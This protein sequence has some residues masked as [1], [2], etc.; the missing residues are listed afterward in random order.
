MAVA[1]AELHRIAQVACSLLGLVLQRWI[2]LQVLK[3]NLQQ[4]D[5]V[6]DPVPHKRAHVLAEAFRLEPGRRQKPR[7]AEH[8][9]GVG[10]WLNA[11]QEVIAK[12]VFKHR[13]L[14][15]TAALAFAT[16]TAA[17]ASTSTIATTSAASTDTTVTITTRKVLTARL[18]MVHM[19]MLVLLVL[20]YAVAVTASTTI[21]ITAFTTT[22][23]AALLFA[24]LGS[25]IGAGTASRRRGRQ[26]SG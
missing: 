13:L 24:R 9:V 8:C 21:I 5:H 20:T 25:R 14:R 26:R 1:P 19:A 2:R 23:A 7:G 12:R 18:V 11:V 16:A 22:A 6:R 3:G 15:P 10:G 4:L 17:N